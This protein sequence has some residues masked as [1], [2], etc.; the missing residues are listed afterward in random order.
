[1]TQATTSASSNLPLL[2]TRLYWLG[3]SDAVGGAICGGWGAAA[4]GSCGGV[5]AWGCCG[6][7]VAWWVESSTT[8]GS[9]ARQPV[10]PNAPRSGRGVTVSRK[11]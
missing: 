1:M 2:T 10:T 6:G 8:F 7:G 4:T 3:S 5:A 9:G 11:N